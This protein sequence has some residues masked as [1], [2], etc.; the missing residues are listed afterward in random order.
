MD[1]NGA[2][3]ISSGQPPEAP[4]QIAGTPSTIPPVVASTGPHIRAST[5]ANSATTMPVGSMPGGSVRAVATH[6]TQAQS[7]I[8]STGAAPSVALPIYPKVVA[9][10]A[11]NGGTTTT[12]TGSGGGGVNTNPHIASTPTTP[13]QQPPPSVGRSGGSGPMGPATKQTRELKVEDALL[14]LDQ[15]KVEFADKPQVYNEFLEIMKNF[16]AQSINTPGKFSAIFVYICIYVCMSI[17][18]YENTPI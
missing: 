7:G 17:C 12:A 8:P 18:M 11:E 15:V 2:M 16:K 3:E 1:P 5:V 14:Y 10:T 4:Q 6:T 13:G 9:A